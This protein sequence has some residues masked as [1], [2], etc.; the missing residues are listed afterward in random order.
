MRV[1]QSTKLGLGWGISKS[2]SLTSPHRSASQQDTLSHL[3]AHRPA[4]SYHS[5]TRLY[6][7]STYLHAPLLV[8]QMLFFC[9]HLSL[10]FQKITLKV[11]ILLFLTFDCK[12]TERPKK[13]YGRFHSSLA[14]TSVTQKNV[15]SE[16]AIYY[17]ACYVFLRDRR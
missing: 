14:L 16:V 12:T 9:K 5:P 8:C 13:V 10:V 7:T 3:V 4:H 15:T 1:Q 2:D 17:C 6:K 11:R